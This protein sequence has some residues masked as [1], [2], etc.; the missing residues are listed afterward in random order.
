MIQTPSRRWARWGLALLAFVPLLRADRAAE[1]VLVHVAALG[2]RERIA[3]LQSYRAEGR[4]IEGD[5]SI[6]LVLVAARP[7]RL[8]VEMRYADHTAVQGCDGIDPPWQSGGAPAGPATLMSPA[9]AETFLHEAEFDD[10][11]V[12]AKAYGCAI[13]LGGD[14]TVEG[15][16][17]LRLLVTQRFTRSFYLLLDPQTYF[18]LQRLEPAGAERPGLVTQYADYRPV[19]GVLFPHH[20]RVIVRGSHARE[21]VLDHIEPNPILS[22]EV[23]KRPE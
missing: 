23:F 6:G 8:R 17:M 18:I 22:P 15:R 13:D 2:G 4:V 11:L 3:A 5:T 16:P 20:L 12:G 21:A 9:A 1:I 7:N 10:P 14:V 19:G